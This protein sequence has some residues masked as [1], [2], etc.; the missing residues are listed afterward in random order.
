MEYTIEDK[1]PEDFFPTNPKGKS[2]NDKEVHK[3]HW[4]SISVLCSYGTKY[5]HI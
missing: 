3:G 4:K 1:L 2:S 5:G